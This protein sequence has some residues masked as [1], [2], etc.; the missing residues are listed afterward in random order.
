MLFPGSPL[1]SRRP[2]N[3]TVL[4]PDAAQLPIGP[5][6][7]VEED[8]S[9]HCYTVGEGG[10]VRSCINGINPIWQGIDWTQCL[11]A[12]GCNSTITPYNM[13]TWSPQCL[14]VAQWNISTDILYIVDTSLNQ[15]D[16]CRPDWLSIVRNT[17][18][19]CTQLHI[20]AYN[21]HQN[22]T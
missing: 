3:S 9:I 6:C 13:L 12:T 5:C 22:L 2:W 7:P 15:T 8:E 20:T 16:I 18:T 4:P 21:R 11:L 1:L 19:K 14:S 10:K 17:T